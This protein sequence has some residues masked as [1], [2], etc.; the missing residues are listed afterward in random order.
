MM[1]R[2]R[3]SAYGI[4]SLTDVELLEIALGIH[5]ADAEMLLQAAGSI[6]RLPK[7]SACDISKRMSLSMVQSERLRESIAGISELARRM[8]RPPPPDRIG[9]SRDVNHKYRRLA[10]LDGEEFWVLVLDSKNRIR[11]EILV[12][13]GGLT[14]CPVNP[15][16]VFRELIREGAYATIFVHNHPSGESSPS[17][18]DVALTDMLC[19]GGE[20]LGLRVVDHIIIGRSDYFSFLDAGMLVRESESA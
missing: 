6:E 13:K 15:A 10:Y 16:D 5:S 9:S 18:E 19:K 14:T 11:G 4:S 7:L 8:D 2:E 1:P 3:R 17:P 12:G 20:M